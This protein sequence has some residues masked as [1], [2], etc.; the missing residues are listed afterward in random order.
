MVDGWASLEVDKQGSHRFELLMYE[1]KGEGQF[2]LLSAK[3]MRERLLEAANNIDLYTSK[4]INLFHL[5]YH[6][7]GL[8]KP[9][10]RPALD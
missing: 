6:E 2:G 8:E 7:K 5:I 10:H 9:E 4:V 3:S 1:R